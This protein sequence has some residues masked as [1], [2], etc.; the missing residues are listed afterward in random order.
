MTTK[1]KKKKPSITPGKTAVM[2]RL[3]EDELERLDVLAN[4]LIGRMPFASRGGLAH[5]AMLI[6]L[7]EI[8]R[9]PAA[10]LPKL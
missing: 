6:G 1:P 8:E 9:D 10:L 7:A 4:A 3:S 5:A 2:L